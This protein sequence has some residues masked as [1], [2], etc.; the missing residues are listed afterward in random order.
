MEA[1]AL[2]TE[3]TDQDRVLLVFGYLGPL[4]LVSLVASRREFVKWHAKQGLVLTAALAVAY[5][6]L[7]FVHFVLDHYL[8]AVFAEMFR[9]G[10]WLVVIGVF[11]T[12]LVCIVRALEGERFRVPVLGELADRL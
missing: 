7:R 6:V 12:M 2:D 8:L 1:S 5:P 10:V 11:M 3:L 4:S 9:A